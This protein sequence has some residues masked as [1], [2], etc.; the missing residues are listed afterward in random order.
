MHDMIYIALLRGINVG[1]KAIVSMA[2]LKVCFEKQGFTDVKTYINSGNVIFRAPK[3]DTEALAAQL[4]T[5]IE[6]SFKLPVRVLVKT[7]E[8]LRTIEAAVPKA[9]DDPTIRCYILF[10]WPSVDAAA[11][12]QTIPLNPTVEKAKYVSGAIIHKYD[13]K[14]ATKSRLNRL[15]GTPLYKDITIRNLNTLR[16]LVKLSEQQ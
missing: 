2:E 9:W 8:Q 7:A 12:L 6:N 11:T 3:V 16:K 13:K 4:E 5:A 15:S 14:D 10:L 1:G